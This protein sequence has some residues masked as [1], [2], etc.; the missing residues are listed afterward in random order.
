MGPTT[1]P[2]YS[3]IPLGPEE[4]DRLQLPTEARSYGSSFSLSQQATGAE[5]APVR[6]RK[7]PQVGRQ[8]LFGL[9]FRPTSASRR[10]SL[11]DAFAEE[12]THLAQAFA[13]RMRGSS[14]VMCYI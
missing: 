13:P 1:G 6:G 4:A 12:Q 10:Q 8:W 9:V 3:L 2:Q 7:D 14:H 5:S 11:E